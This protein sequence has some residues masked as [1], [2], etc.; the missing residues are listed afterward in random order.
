MKRATFTSP[1]F[2]SQDRR[3]KGRRPPLQ[4]PGG[5]PPR[6]AN[7]FVSGSKRGRPL[8]TQK[9]YGANPTR[10][11]SAQVR[12]SKFAE[13]RPVDRSSIFPPHKSQRYSA[14][15]SQ[16]D[17]VRKGQPS[18]SLQNF[19]PK[20]KPK[21]WQ[22][23]TQKPTTSFWQAAQNSQKEWIHKRPHWSVVQW[24]LGARQRQWQQMTSQKMQRQLLQGD[25]QLDAPGV[26]YAIILHKRQCIY[27]GQTVNSAWH[28]FK[29]HI[30]GKSKAGVLERQLQNE[31]QNCPPRDISIIPLEVIPMPENQRQGRHTREFI[32]EFRKRALPR[33][34]QWIRIVR[35][36]NAKILNVV[37]EGPK[38][39]TQQR[40][41]RRQSQPQKRPP[42]V[43]DKPKS[44]QA[45]SK[46]IF[47]NDDRIILDSTTPGEFSRVRKS[48]AQL[49]HDQ[50][51][52]LDP[53][54]RLSGWSKSYRRDIILFLIDQLD[55]KE[56]NHEKSKILFK[57]LST[58]E[59]TN[60]PT[61]APDSSLPDID[62]TSQRQKKKNKANETLWLRIPWSRHDFKQLKLDQI[63]QSKE[64]CQ[65]HPVPPSVK[66]TRVSYSL[67]R[68]LGV[69]FSNF[70]QT[71]QEL[72]GQTLPPCPSPEDCPCRKYQSPFSLTFNGH[73]V[74]TDPTVFRDPSLRQLWQCG[75][76]FRIPAH[77]MVL[78]PDIKKGLEEYCDRLARAHRIGIERFEPWQKYI[79]HA[80]EQ[81]LTNIS[82][83][84]WL[85][86][87]G[88]TQQGFRELRKV[89]TDMVIGPCDKS[90][91]D[92]M[93]ICKHAYVHALQNELLSGVYQ[94]TALTDEQIWGN[95][96]KFSQEIG[97]IPVNSHAYLYG[98]AKMHKEPANMRWI[99]GCSRQ[100]I[101]KK[102]ER[103]TMSAAT[104]ISPLAAAL[105]AI[106]RFCMIQ[107][108]RKDVQKFRPKGIRRYWIV[109]SVDAVAK[110]IKTH[111]K[112][113]A[114]EEVY[115][116]DFTTMYTKLPPESI[117]EGV[118]AAVTEAFQ[119]FNPKATFNF[120][121][122]R[123]GKAE[124]VIEDNGAF[125]L[126][127]AIDWIQK[128]VDG[129]YI[130]PCPNAPT[131]QQVV[132]VPM[133]GKC[134]SELANL[135][136]YFVESTT[137][138][139][140][141]AQ[142]AM[143]TAKSF[144]HT[145][146]Y[147]DDILGFGANQLQLLP[148]NMEHRRTNDNPKEA[149]FLGMSI[150]TNGD[151][152]KLKLQP[153]GAGRKWTPQRY[154]EWS[155]VHTAATKKFLL[156]GLLVR[157]STVTN[158]T[159]NFHVAVK[160]YVQGLFARGFSRRAM[161]DAFQS[162]I[163]DYWKAYPN[164]QREL[165]KWFQGLLSRTFGNNTAPPK[166]PTIAQTTSQGTL[167]C[168]LDAINHI[169]INQGRMPVTRDILD[170]I[171]NNVASLEAMITN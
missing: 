103:T 4:Q 34:Q 155:S 80:I 70:T 140:L 156:K 165:S 54:D 75:R 85:T 82:N 50:Q 17:V 39:R 59:D 168:G 161:H 119:F 89:Q 79:I 94:L 46:W 135:Y 171:A 69:F 38:A 91:H 26:I 51:Q 153:K 99:A 27:I 36:A 150:D 31:L 159:P 63:I 129:T 115:T 20:P 77:P 111:Q 42:K 124:A 162:Y 86:C 136:C 57:F 146:R 78:L 160:Y 1:P 139:R 44:P 144:Y 21:R 35:G 61:T 19:P 88:L 5:N 117:K 43:K 169:M 101:E 41:Q 125:C 128:V 73:V 25:E 24:V 118:K 3:P 143:E 134:S 93:L 62:T 72:D 15:P 40:R 126:S 138:D 64:S 132:G 55:E 112:E 6:R 107:L 141:I 71:C 13:T 142:G 83:V 68:P 130:K 47:V 22:D 8:P 52:G 7:S 166:G 157:A 12:G 149:V 37:K 164:Q 152:V 110:H 158:T 98:A 102:G 32:E 53:I 56:T 65:A 33:E 105:G 23:R 123:K 133:G 16:A 58:A 170:D 2:G 97:R 48:L 127:H 81:K 121:W 108:E 67:N 154:V 95:H 131:R 28:R 9:G 74:S 10:S 120:K 11:P 90:A 104:S 145:F 167:L 29:Q 106:L 92:L 147:I 49:L 76:K 84:D 148:Y 45:K 30:Y 18:R 109:T 137:I 100:I 87:G 60:S 122:D 96:A 66:W 113:L 151:F 114:Q 14:P 116:E 163:H